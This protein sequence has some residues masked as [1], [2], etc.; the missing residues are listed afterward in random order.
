[1]YTVIVS[2]AEIY[3]QKTKKKGKICRKDRPGNIKEVG[4]LVTRMKQIVFSL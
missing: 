2:I 3:K 1:M 4:L